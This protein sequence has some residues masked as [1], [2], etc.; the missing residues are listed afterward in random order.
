MRNV[1]ESMQLYRRSMEELEQMQK[2][3]Q[4]QKQE[5]E[6]LQVWALQRSQAR[7]MLSRLIVSFASGSGPIRFLAPFAY[8][9][10]GL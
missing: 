3:H 4:S 1:S 7:Q 2:Q 10:S 8:T 6:R 9:T 5:L